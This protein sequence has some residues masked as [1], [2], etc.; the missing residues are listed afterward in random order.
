MLY[1][2][3][4][5]TGFLSVILYDL[6][7]I[8]GMRGAASILSSIGYLCILASIVFLMI[9]VHPRTI[10]LEF[11][12]VKGFLTSVFLILLIYSVGFE[13][14]IA[15]RRGGVKGATE[16]R[17]VAT[18]FYG[19]V[20]HPGFVWFA[21]LWASIIF[22]YQ[23]AVVAAVGIALVV[24]DFVLIVLEDLVF[25]PRIFCDY[26]EYKHRVPFLV[27]RMKRR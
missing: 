2:T 19:M 7:Q 6:A 22:L 4:G 8:R 17:V 18:G 1:L 21:L 24:I 26:E 12:I 5:A 27:P 14:P 25:F 10:A 9:T 20:R 15:L 3:V 23:D 11:L 13:I 16:R